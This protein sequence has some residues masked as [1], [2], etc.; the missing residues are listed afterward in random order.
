MRSCKANICRKTDY[1]E[2]ALIIHIKPNLWIEVQVFR[3]ASVAVILGMP[4]TII[5]RNAKT[6]I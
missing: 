2:N 1:T 3:S 4:V 6:A 5:I